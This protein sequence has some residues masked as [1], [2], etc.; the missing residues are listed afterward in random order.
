M[1]PVKTVTDPKIF[2]VIDANANRLT[3]GLRVCEDIARFILS[4][5][6][7]VRRFKALRHKAFIAAECLG[8]DKRLI[9]SFRDSESDVGKV[10]I[11][12]ENRRSSVRDIFKAN[13]K[14]SEESMRVL[15][16]FAK[17]SNPASADKF[18]KMRFE[19]YFLE[20]LIIG[21]FKALCD[22]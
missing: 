9:V 22:N 5:G 20:K 3:E 1:F 21:K 4:D 7:S 6:G 18:K 14:R 11:E 8:A 10:S 16:E 2:R 17:L 12:N 13:I 19:L 15:E